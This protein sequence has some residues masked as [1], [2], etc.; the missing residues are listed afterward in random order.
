M[1]VYEMAAER[2]GRQGEIFGA[3]RALVARFGR[4]GRFSPWQ[5]RPGSPEPGYRESPTGSRSPARERREPPT[6]RPAGTPYLDPPSNSFRSIASA[7]NW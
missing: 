6:A 3:R 7:I 5:A 4:S 2:R 1:A